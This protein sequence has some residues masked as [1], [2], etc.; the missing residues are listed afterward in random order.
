MRAQLSHVFRALVVLGAVVAPPA[1]AGELTGTVKFDGP[2]PKLEPF[3]ATR[4]QN[5]CGPAVPNESEEVSNGRLANVVVTV[6]GTSV[7]KLSCASPQCSPVRHARSKSGHG[8]ANS[9]DDVPRRIA[10]PRL[11]VVDELVGERLHG[12]VAGPGNVRRDDRVRQPGD[13]HDG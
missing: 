5:V 2:A 10:I 1:R 4:D 9:H 8:E 11:D 6:A 7:P 12:A 13:L 3:K